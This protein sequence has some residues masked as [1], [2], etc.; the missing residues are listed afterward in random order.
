V[1][2]MVLRQAA[3]LSYNDVFRLLGVMFLLMLP[4]IALMK[5]PK[6]GGPGMGH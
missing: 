5:K 6:G 3:I 2:E 1:W 4:M